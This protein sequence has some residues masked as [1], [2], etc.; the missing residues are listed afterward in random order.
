MATET[1][2]TLPPNVEFAVNAIL[3]VLGEPA[4]GWQ[5]FALTKYKDGDAIAV[6]M[7]NASHL[8][9]YYCKCLAFLSALPTT[10][11]PQK[12]LSAAANAAADH[13]Q[14]KT[15]DKI[16]DGNAG[17]FESDNPVSNAT[18]N[19]LSFLMPSNGCQQLALALG[20]NYSA[21][22]ELQTQNPD[23]NLIKA[24]IYLSKASP[25]SPAFFTILAEA[26]TS[27][28]GHIRSLEHEKIIKAI[29]QVLE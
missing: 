17:A 15:L 18:E 27:A 16:S 20:N 11:N 14:L 2:T 3:E 8:R 25:D 19:I 21:L 28:A 24:L 7:V 1:A 4:N 29:S 10:P 26:G 13:A 9:D 22:K 5:E 6:K 12:V 23:D